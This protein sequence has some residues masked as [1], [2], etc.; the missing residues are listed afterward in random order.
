MPCPH[1]RSARK[2]MSFVTSRDFGKNA[3][4]RGLALLAVACMGAGTA[5]AQD[6][7]KPNEAAAVKPGS[8]EAPKAGTDELGFTADQLLY[9]NDRDVVTAEGN[10]IVTREQNVLRANMVIWDRKSNTVTAKGDVSITQ[11]DG[12]V[13]Y[14]D[15]VDVTDTLKDGVVKGLLVVTQQGDR[16]AAEQ[17]E[18]R[19]AIFILNH[20]AYSPCEVIDDRGCAKA[21][22]WQIKAARVVYDSDREMVRY[23][24]ARLEM[25]GVP[26][27]PLPGLTHPVGNR[28]GSGILVPD[29][30][31]INGGVEFALPYYWSLA[32]NH[33]LTITPHVYTNAWPMMQAKYRSF[34]DKGAFEVSGYAT[35]GRRT[36]PATGSLDSKRTVRAYIDASGKFQLSPEW[37]ISGSVQRVTDRTFLRRYN[38]NWDDRLRS[39]ITAERIGDHSYLSIAGWSFQTLR[40]NDPQGQVPIAL[41]VIDY[42][43]RLNDPWVGGT[44]QLQANSLAI[45]R[46]A[47]QD[48]QRAFVG[49][50]WSLRRLMGLGQ[51]VVLT[52]YARGDVY[53]SSDN[54]L[55]NT[56]IYQGMPGWQ[57][58]G[59][60]AA[61]AEIR[62][63]FVGELMGGTQHIVPRVQVVVS[64]PLE[65]LNVPNEDARAVDLEDSNLFA[66]N[67]FPGYDRFEDSTRVTYGFDYRYD[68]PYFSVEATIGQSYRLNN[69][70]TILPDGTGLSGRLL[71]IVGRIDV[72]Y[73][74]FVTLTHRFRLDK[75]NL[76]VRRNEFDATIGSHQTYVKVSYLRLNRNITTGI[77]DLRDVE[78]VRLGGR[79][80]MGRYWSVFGSTIVDLTGKDDDPTTNLSGY[81]PIRHYVGVSYEDDCINIGFTWRRQ[82]Q[83][84]GDAYRGNSFMVR[85]AFRNLGI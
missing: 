3:P 53:H 73:R 60:V 16:I 41:P 27:V 1:G 7:V 39:N 34:L 33:D 20:A 47:G 69:R 81:T 64:P 15:T 66:I 42:R 84:L 25:F 30:G 63:P 50:Q 74:D 13:A 80:A 23:R 58:R 65:N 19:G 11:P 26:L 17:G 82:Y 36:D 62:W 10:V 5:R 79:V 78:E 18:R 29:I 51:E 14:G 61:A 68:R 21:P 71:D 49:A 76:A 8:A 32:P 12:S 2:R 44:V 85:L 9:D 72:R 59:I 75:D 52:G 45:S 46:T 83:N 56:I 48:T 67:R 57:T 40:P 77:E 54:S 28:S 4:V 22:T 35:Y 55:T 31:S 37:S 70:A 43:L 38:L 6:L 24:G